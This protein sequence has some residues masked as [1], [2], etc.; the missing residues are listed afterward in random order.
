MHNLT[1]KQLL[2]VVTAWILTLVLGFL[3]I[4]LKT[5]NVYQLSPYE[6]LDTP[7][8][9]LFTTSVLL[10]SYY[11]IKDSLAIRKNEPSIYAYLGVLG[12][13]INVTLIILLPFSRGYFSLRADIG[14]HIRVSQDIVINEIIN[15][16]NFYPALYGFFH[17][18]QAYTGVKV[19]DIWLLGSVVS[20]FFYIGSAYIIGSRFFKIRR[21]GIWLSLCAAT[22]AAG[23]YWTPLSP[24]SF[25]VHLFFF[26]FFIYMSSRE[27]TSINY[28]I[29]LLMLVI[30]YPYIHPLT[31]IICVVF[32]TLFE[33]FRWILKTKLFNE[34]DYLNFSPSLLL[35]I[36]WFLWFTNFS[37]F[38]FSVM[39][40]SNWFVG[41][42]TNQLGQITS[43]IE[44]TSYSIYE[45]ALLIFKQANGVLIYLLISLSSSLV[46][47]F[48]WNR[49]KTGNIPIIIVGSITLAIIAS[50]ISVLVSLVGPFGNLDF[51]RFTR[52][53]LP[54][55]TLGLISV[56]LL[57][58]HHGKNNNFSI[59]LLMT[60]NSFLVALG[61]LAMH[62]SPYVLNM[63][64]QLTEQEVQCMRWVFQQPSNRDIVGIS[65]LF[66][67]ALISEGPSVARM[68]SGLRVRIPDHFGFPFYTKIADSYP[69]PFFLL[70]TE[71]NKKMYLELYSMAGRFNPQDFI[72]LEN[73]LSVMAIYSN[74]QCSIWSTAM[75]AKNNRR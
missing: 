38:A 33:T 26:L 68:T 14:V 67:L 69:N 51:Y 32:I 41:E 63:N 25:S 6:G 22:P 52:Y 8:W 60:A 34:I 24:S 23:G 75:K 30:L 62:P 35:I 72:R 9:V 40:M 58:V 48:I 70:I 65:Q 13:A 45:S 7:F 2:F 64:D 31:S 44:K 43:L 56:P 49:K 46:L 11:P 53:L 1:L 18:I 10:H 5:T 36:S 61:S 73:D 57:L 39:Y 71:H 66:N 21:Y 29:I 20:Y 50:S 17:F 54:W 3:L 12:I 19:R 59:F 47:L 15:K 28:R 55:S 16:D 27:S 37:V 4:N 74:N 42:A